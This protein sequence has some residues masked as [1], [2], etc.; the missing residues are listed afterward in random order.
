M[1]T[2]FK[3][4]LLFG[5]AAVLILSGFRAMAAE[6]TYPD[7]IGLPNINNVDPKSET[8]LALLVEFWFGFATYVA[9]FLAITSFGIGAIQL[10]FSASSPEAH[11]NAKDRMK[12]SVFG[13]VLTISAYIILQTIN[14]AFV[15]STPSDLSLSS[16]VYLSKGSNYISASTSISDTSTL[17]GYTRIYN[18][19][20]DGRYI[21]VW[22]FAK[23]NY[24]YGPGD[25]TL[26]IPCGKDENISNAGSYKWAYE[27]PGVYYCL[28]GCSG[29]FCSGFM[30]EVRINSENEI[31]VP[32]RGASIGVRIVNDPNS[33][34]Y[35]GAIAHK[36]INTSNGGLCTQPILPSNAS[37]CTNTEL[38]T[39]SLDIFKWNKTN[40]TAS[41]DG[42]TLYGETYGWNADVQSGFYNIPQTNINNFY[43]QNADTFKFDYTNIKSNDAAA[44][45]RYPNLSCKKQNPANDEKTLIQ[46]GNCCPCLTFQDCPGSIRI[47]GNYV[48]AIY[49]HDLNNNLYCQTFIKDVES[50]N[51]FKYVEPGKKIEYINIIPTSI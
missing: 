41:G 27:T 28:S 43:K 29:E 37:S 20:S 38:L 18:A 44:C 48:A 36:E 11:N 1:K 39:Y 31:P 30:S 47:K 33:S 5:F 50:M 40:S 26:R 13:L 21:L 51:A 16:G 35:Y 10:I 19:C 46:S 45:N 8:G 17:N 3:L 15:N 4:L 12:G 25:Q 7:I 9:G 32:F 34:K 42:L 2:S 23:K 14:P 49:S 6:I 22:L 24:E